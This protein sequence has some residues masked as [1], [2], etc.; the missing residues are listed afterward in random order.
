MKTEEVENLIHQNGI[1][2]NIRCF[3]ISENTKNGKD[4]MSHVNN[5]KYNNG[6]IKIY[7]DR[8]SFLN[9]EKILDQFPICE[10]LVKEKKGKQS[11]TIKLFCKFFKSENQLIF[12]K[13]LGVKYVDDEGKEVINKK[14]GG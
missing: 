11:N 1:G 9:H 13:L 2:Q 6:I 5:Y 12:V 3:F 10:L 14:V 7:M 8:S 4:F